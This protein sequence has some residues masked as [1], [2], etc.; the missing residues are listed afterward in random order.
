[1]SGDAEHDEDQI[2]EAHGRAG[3]QGRAD[4]GGLDRGERL[5]MK[6]HNLRTL[7]YLLER[8][9]QTI[10]PYDYVVNWQKEIRERIGKKAVGLA[11]IEGKIPLE[12]VNFKELSAREKLMS[13]VATAVQDFLLKDF[14]GKEV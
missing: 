5:T 14:L 3:A 12:E 4:G 10:Q 11:E 13:E 9:P 8:Y 6:T 1:M 2:G 7:K